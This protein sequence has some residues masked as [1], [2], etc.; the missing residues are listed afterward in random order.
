VNP[1]YASPLRKA[2][3]VDSTY[4]SPDY[5]LKKASRDSDIIEGSY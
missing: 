2:K 5:K 4:A 1:E 3:K